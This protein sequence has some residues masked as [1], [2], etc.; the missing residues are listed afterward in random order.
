MPV[1]DLWFDWFL[2][3]QV[4]G[5]LEHRQRVVRHIEMIR[6]RVLDAAHLNEGMTLLDVGSGYGLLAFGAIERIGS[7]LRAILAEPSESLL[8]SSQQF[9]KE[10]G[11][12]TQCSFQNVPATALSVADGSVDVAVAR[13]VLTFVPDKPAALRQMY[14]ALR[15]GGR[16]SIA[17]PIMQDDAFELVGL[18]QLVESQANLPDREFLRLLARCR[19]F[20]YP[21]TMEAMHQ[22][23]LTQ[24]S[25]RDYVAA[26]RTVGFINIH[27]E[28][29][30]DVRTSDVTSW[31][32]FIDLLPHPFALTLRQ[33][34]K[35]H[36]S[37]DERAV[38]ERNL[39]P[40]V[41]Q[42]GIVSPEVTAYLSAD[43]PE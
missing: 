6:D 4:G 40:R 33:I 38:V 36:L 16:L 9:A 3:S 1:S 39:R 32:V 26:A 42:G 27:M 14:R 20:V 7:S 2:K 34:M 25:E 5:D 17:E 28:L 8:S 15:P 10:R 13:A 21:T 23:P 19:S 11:I 41:E 24:F 35:E 18:V 43:K 31:D 22:N 37:A 30:M 12:D 29:H